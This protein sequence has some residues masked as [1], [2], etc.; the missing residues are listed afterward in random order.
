MKCKSCKKELKLEDIDYVETGTLLYRL[1]WDGEYFGFELRD[2]NGD[3][4]DYILVCDYC[5]YILDLTLDELAEKIKNK[6]VKTNE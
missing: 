2:A 6:E 3:S 1:S 4:T 5:G